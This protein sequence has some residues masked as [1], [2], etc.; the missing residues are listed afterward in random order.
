MVNLIQTKKMIRDIHLLKKRVDLLIIYLHFG[1]EY[2]H[3]P[4]LKQKQLVNL[5]FK[6]GA[7]IILGS[8]P[9]VLQP[10]IV[11]GKQRLAMYSLGNFIS[12]KLRGNVHTQSSIILNIKVKKNAEG[13]IIIAETNYIPTL[14]H[15]RLEKGR[16]KTEV[17]SIHEAFNETNPKL[18]AKSRKRLQH[19]LNQTIKIIKSKV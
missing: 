12:T 8:H 19:M 3:T 14:V 17:I 4:N 10:L 2:S 1:N 13:K 11:Q 5:L 16:Y 18:R 6:H 7:H 9:H 15:R